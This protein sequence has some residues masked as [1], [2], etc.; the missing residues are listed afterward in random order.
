MYALRSLDVG[1]CSL[2]LVQQR[3]DIR[4]TARC[5]ERGSRRTRTSLITN[6]ATQTNNSHATTDSA[7]FFQRTLLPV[8]TY[9]VGYLRPVSNNCSLK[10]A[11]STPD[12]IYGLG[13]LQL[14]IGEASTTITV[15]SASGLVER[16]EPQAF[17]VLRNEKLSPLFPA[18][19]KT[20]AWIISLCS[21][22]ECDNGDLAFPI[23]T[24]RILGQRAARKKQRPTDRRPK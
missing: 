16:T 9:S 14:D 8:G 24:A 23:S 3:L 4:D 5:S 6:I 13:T 10:G 20:M 17:A 22:L 21:S 12:Q 1:R 18:F 19:R 7:G 2:A 15:R 11:P